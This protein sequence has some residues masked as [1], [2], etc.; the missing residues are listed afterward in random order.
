MNEIGFPYRKAKFYIPPKISKDQRWHI[1]WH[2]LDISEGKM[3]R[4]KDRSIN[5]YPIATRVREAKNLI[6]VINQQL[7]K[8][9]IKDKATAKVVEI[10]AQVTHAAETIGT[11]EA[12][13]Q[14]LKWY[15]H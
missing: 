10:E 4:D 2:W 8:G 1:E 11:C 12:I 14:I 6:K 3:I 9:F 7:R 13:D 5:E 15:K